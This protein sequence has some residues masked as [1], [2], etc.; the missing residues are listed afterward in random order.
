MEKNYDDFVQ[1]LRKE[2]PKVKFIEFHARSL[3]TLKGIMVTITDLGLFQTLWKIFELWLNK[4]NNASIKVSYKSTEDKLI[5]ITYNSLNKNE[6]E[7]ILSRNPPAIDRPT[8]IIL[9][10]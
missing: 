10:E 3:E 6:V 8:K 5:E 2:L 1:L 9:T 4:H 7:D